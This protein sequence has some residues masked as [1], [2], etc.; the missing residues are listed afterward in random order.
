[1][2]ETDYCFIGLVIYG[3]WYSVTDLALD[4][5]DDYWDYKSMDQLLL[6][7]VQVNE[8]L[9]S[10]I[11]D[12]TSI[13][14]Y[15]TCYC[16]TSCYW[17]MLLKLLKEYCQIVTHTLFYCSTIYTVILSSLLL[18]PSLTSLLSPYRLSNRNNMDIDCYK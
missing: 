8:I 17:F 4:V 7:A 1:M 9:I 13:R 3:T 12:C 2:R 10:S 15:V 14:R 11:W 18:L 16:T 6:Y 5:H